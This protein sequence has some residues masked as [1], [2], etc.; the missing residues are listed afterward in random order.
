MLIDFGRGSFSSSLVEKDEYS[1][2]KIVDR[3]TLLTLWHTAIAKDI[4]DY[5][6]LIWQLTKRW[7]ELTR[8]TVVPVPLVDLIAK[9]LS[10]TD[11][12]TMDEVTRSFESFEDR[13]IG[14]SWTTTSGSAFTV[15]EAESRL[16]GSVPGD[17]EISALTHSYG[18]SELTY[19]KIRPGDVYSLTSSSGQSF[20][21]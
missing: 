14:D 16:N 19:R 6:R 3:S 7:M 13:F 5:G 11:Q 10:K 18:M 8:R 9:C 21:F 15:E 17:V 12:P 4:Y 2:Q 20:N 1:E